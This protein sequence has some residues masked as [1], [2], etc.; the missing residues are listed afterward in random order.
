MG[1]VGRRSK[2]SQGGNRGEE[3]RWLVGRDLWGFFRSRWAGARHG[4]GRRRACIAA[5][6]T[7]ASLLGREDGRA[8]GGRFAWRESAD[9]VSA[10]FPAPAR[11]G[12]RREMALRG[13]KRRDDPHEL[14]ILIRFGDGER[15]GRGPSNVSTMIIRPPQHGHR[16]SG[17]GGSVSLSASAGALWGE[18][19]GAAS[20]WRARSMLRART[21][22]AM[23]P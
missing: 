10:R 5:G 14:S 11:G 1:A 6:T 23:R 7:R 9:L 17:E 22:P 20:A 2:A 16:C 12:R 18:T 21:V 8:W 19:L 4:G 15:A 13:G 3:G